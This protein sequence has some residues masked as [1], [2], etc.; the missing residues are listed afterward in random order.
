[1]HMFGPPMDTRS[2]VSLWG[3]SFHMSLVSDGHL[4]SAI[5]PEKYRNLEAPRDDFRSRFRILGS[6]ADTRA[7]ASVYGREGGPRIPRWTFLE[8]DV[9]CA[10]WFNS[11]YTLTRQSMEV[12]ISHVPRV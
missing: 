8:D 6:A 7:H 11:G 5:S 4:F 1:M 9:R 12:L 10:A 2:C 3:C